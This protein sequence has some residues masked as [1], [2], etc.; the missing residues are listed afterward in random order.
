LIAALRAFP[1]IGLLVSH[2]RAL[3]DA[4]CHQCLFLEEH[5][6]V[7]KTYRLGIWLP[8]AYSS[9]N[10]LLAL[11]AGTLPLEPVRQLHL[12]PLVLQ[13][14]DR[15]ALTGPNGGGKSTLVRHIVASARCP[16]NVCSISRR[17][18][19]AARPGRC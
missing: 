8:G 12:P 14:R 4:L 15:I 13:P 6:V 10:T 7:S 18:L 17:K 11:A 9:R 19:T 16:R 1:S 3:L 2:D 5:S